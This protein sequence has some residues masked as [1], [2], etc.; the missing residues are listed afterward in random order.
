MYLLNEV[1]HDILAMQYHGNYIEVKKLFFKFL[2]F[3]EVETVFNHGPC[4]VNCIDK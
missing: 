2:H 4:V 3:K 1:K